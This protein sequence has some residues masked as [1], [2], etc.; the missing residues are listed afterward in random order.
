MDAEGAG[1]KQRGERCLWWVMGSFI[2]LSTP[3]FFLEL[4]HLQ[5]QQAWCAAAPTSLPEL[6]LVETKRLPLWVGGC[7]G[8]R[9]LPGASLVIHLSGYEPNGGVHDVSLRHPASFALRC[10][11]T[12]QS[13][14]GKPASWAAFLI[15][16]PLTVLA[17]FSLPQF[18][19]FFAGSSQ[20]CE[21]QRLT[22]CTVLPAQP[23]AGMSGNIWCLCPFAE[24]TQG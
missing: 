12:S 18:L 6:V 24:S 16:R 3:R 1:G 2:C 17:L 8:H 9:E 11:G 4:H 14:S 10:G 13:L 15:N 7:C 23:A 20:C 5:V 19:L 21:P 22:N